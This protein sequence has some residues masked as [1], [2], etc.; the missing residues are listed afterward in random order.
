MA[1]FEDET[2]RVF[3]QNGRVKMEAEY[4]ESV[5]IR[6]YLSALANFKRAS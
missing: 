6:K 2:L 1:S 3:G 5:V 4:D